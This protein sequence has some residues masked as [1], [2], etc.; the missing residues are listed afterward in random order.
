MKPEN[1]WKEGD[2]CQCDPSGGWAEGSFGGNQICEERDKLKCQNGCCG[3]S[4]C[5]GVHQTLEGGTGYWTY[6]LPTSLPKWSIGP[7]TGCY[8]SWTSSPL[9][10]RNEKSLDCDK[11]GVIVVSNRLLVPPDNIAFSNEGMM[12]HAWIDTPIG[13]TR[14]S[15]NRKALTLIMD[16]ANFK[17]PIAFILPDYFGNQGKWQDKNGEYQVSGRLNCLLLC[18]RSSLC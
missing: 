1:D 8:S 3:I 16:T 13:K 10:V 5:G 15:D 2:P 11:L 12:G 6:K 9:D 4:G 14:A 18:F 7:V 17:G